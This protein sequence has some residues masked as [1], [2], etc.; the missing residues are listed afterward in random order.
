MILN[1]IDFFTVEENTSCIL[2]LRTS[3][4]LNLISRLQILSEISQCK[5]NDVGPRPVYAND[6]NP[7]SFMDKYKDLYVGI[8]CL[9]D[10]YNIKCRPNSAPKIHAPRKVTFLL[11]QPFV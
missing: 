9:K 4:N 6:Q 5:V 11:K 8:A 7:A 10:K 1:H 2:G 3:V